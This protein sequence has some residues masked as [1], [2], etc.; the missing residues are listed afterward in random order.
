LLISCFIILRFV[1][2]Y[3]LIIIYQMIH[4]HFINLLLIFCFI[5]LRFVFDYLL[6]IVYWTIH[7]IVD[8]SRNLPFT[9]LH[10]T[11]F[12]GHLIT[13]KNLRPPTFIAR[14]LWRSLD[15]LERGSLISLVLEKAQIM[16]GWMLVFFEGRILV[17]FAFR[18]FFFLT[19]TKKR[20]SFI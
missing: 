17:F 7:T 10:V 2:D 15:Y 19:K 18:F 16:G 9:L 4:R 14:M 13:S 1:S 8:L 6:I 3:L 20:Y 5:I 12:G 11:W